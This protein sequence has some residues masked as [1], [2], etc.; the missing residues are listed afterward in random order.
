MRSY[1]VPVSKDF[2]SQSLSTQAKK[3]EYLVS[4]MPAS[5]KAFSLLGDDINELFTENDDFE[6]KRGS[7]DQQWLEESKAKL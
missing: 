5:K 3:G 1:T 2:N 6:N 4:R 7:N